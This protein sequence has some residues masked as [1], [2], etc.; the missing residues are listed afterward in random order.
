MFTWWNPVY[1]IFTAPALLFMLYAQWRVRSA[2]NKWEQVPNAHNLTGAKAAEKLLAE[3]GL[4]GVGIRGIPGKMTDNYD[5]RSNTLS[6]SEGTARYGSVASLAI[7]A[8]EIGHA[9]QDYKG[10]LL[11]KARIGLVPAVN[12][13]AQF[14]PMLFIVG[15]L[16]QFTP[17]M[18]LG[19]GFF[20]LSFVFALMTLPLEIDAS[21]RAMKMLRNSSLLVGEREIRG[22]RQVLNAAALTYVAAMLTALAQLL[23]YVFLARGSRRRR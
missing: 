7:V 20:S 8:H 2:Y 21:A 12:I 1:W 6:L 4:Q 5:P 13:G 11:L 19:V 23:Y 14:G 10:S 3:T 18:W 15:Y 16:L 17:L 22:A 9:Q